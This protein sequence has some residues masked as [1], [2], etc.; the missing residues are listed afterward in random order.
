MSVITVTYDSFESVTSLP[1][2]VF[3]DCWASWCPPCRRFAPIF[4]KAADDHPDITF[5]TIDTEKEDRLAG[6]LM[7]TSIPLIMAFRDGILVFSQPGAL[8][9][10]TFAKLIDTVQGLDMEKVRADL[11]E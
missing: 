10:A 5:G 6:K 9:A 2:V 1:G 7:I 4:E 8:N 11:E 3:I